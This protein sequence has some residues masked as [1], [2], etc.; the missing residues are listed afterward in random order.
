MFIAI[1]LEIRA[2]PHPQVRVDVLVKGRDA[3]KALS[4]LFLSKHQH[5]REREHLYT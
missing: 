3:G 2:S 1:N 5:P 4:F